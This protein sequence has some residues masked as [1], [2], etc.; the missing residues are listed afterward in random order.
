MPKT[1][2]K[3][4]TAPVTAGGRPA[5]ETVIAL[6]KYKASPSQ[7]TWDEFGRKLDKLLKCALPRTSDDQRQEAAVILIG[8]TARLRQAARIR[9]ISASAKAMLKLAQKSLSRAKTRIYRKNEHQ[10]K[11]K[12]EVIAYQAIA[13]D[14]PHSEEVRLRKAGVTLVSEAESGK[15]IKP[16]EAKILLRLLREEVSRKELAAEL[17]ITEPAVSLRIKRLLPKLQ[18]LAGEI[19]I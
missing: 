18:K 8:N 9:S 6:R 5:L 13:Q 17:G 10:K 1:T 11:I 7:K 3:P 4:K 14:Q 12:A 15:L 19:E 2:I 16:K